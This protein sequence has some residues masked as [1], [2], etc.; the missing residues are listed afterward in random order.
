M[1]RARDL[2]SLDNEKNSHGFQSRASFSRPWRRAAVFWLRR[3]EADSICFMQLDVERRK[4]RSDHLNRALEYQLEACREDAGL[5]AMLLTDD[6]GLAV[7]ASGEA[8][9]CDELAA[10][11]ALIGRKVPEFVGILFSA[12][13]SREVSMQRFAIDG[14]ELY[15]CAVGGG[16]DP[17]ARQIRRSIGGCARILGGCVRIVTRA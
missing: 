11:L 7:A 10:R 6:E 16:P 1:V 12:E 5:E 4:R 15:M 14:A 9:A 17:R 2:L 3:R 13:G 8:G